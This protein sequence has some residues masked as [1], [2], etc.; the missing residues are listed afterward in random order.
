M[1]EDLEKELTPEEDREFLN[2]SDL[3]RRKIISDLLDLLY[4]GMPYWM[5]DVIINSFPRYAEDFDGK[6]FKDY[7]ENL[8]ILTYA[9][10]EETP[11]ED[12]CAFV[13]HAS[14]EEVINK[15]FG[16]WLYKFYSENCKEEE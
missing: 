8:Q 1:N 14:S 15:L 4:E 12:R 6:R 7:F 3:E 5:K 2:L 16:D 9:F 10:S 13:L 11:L